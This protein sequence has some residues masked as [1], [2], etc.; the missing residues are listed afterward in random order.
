MEI[1]LIIF[2]ELISAKSPQ[3]VANFSATRR[4]YRAIYNACWGQRYVEQAARIYTGE[5]LK[6]SLFIGCVYDDNESAEATDSSRMS[7]AQIK[8]KIT[9]PT[10]KMFENAI[11]WHHRVGKITEMEGL[12][13]Y[14]SSKKRL[15][16]E[17]EYGQGMWV[18]GAYVYALSFALNATSKRRVNNHEE[19]S[20]LKKE[21]IF[22]PPPPQVVCPTPAKAWIRY[23]KA[24]RSRSVHIAEC[25]SNGGGHGGIF[26]PYT[27][28]LVARHA[29]LISLARQLI[30]AYEHEITETNI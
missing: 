10:P 25:I 8:R 22:P 6:S 9:N 13:S 14:K 21:G 7:I 11:K 1:I 17:K 5:F 16:Y 2:E 27:D 28:R 30:P 12:G 19:L 26:G 15:K 23:N 18:H 24:C 29:G 3:G 20:K 4:V